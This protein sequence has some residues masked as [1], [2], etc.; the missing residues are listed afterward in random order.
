MGLP[1]QDGEQDGEQDE[2]QNGPRGCDAFAHQHSFHLPI[3][4]LGGAGVF[5]LVQRDQNTKDK[6]R[7]SHTAGR[8]DL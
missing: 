7:G 5:P 8:V 4:A 2:M 1:S 3:S 6:R